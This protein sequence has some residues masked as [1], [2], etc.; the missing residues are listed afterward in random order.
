M[1]VKEQIQVRIS[2]MS[3][4]LENFMMMMMMMWASS[5]FGKVLE[6]I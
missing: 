1:G 5:R 4:A 2:N 3:A 6:R